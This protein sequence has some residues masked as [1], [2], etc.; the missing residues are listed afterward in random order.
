MYTKCSINVNYYHFPENAMKY[1]GSVW[2]K[3]SV[4]HQSG[5]N[6]LSITALKSTAP[7]PH[8]T[9]CPH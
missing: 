1:S 6:W 5:I 7:P 8:L 9:Q 4:S 3:S 2:Y